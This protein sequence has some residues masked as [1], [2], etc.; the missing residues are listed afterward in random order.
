MK[1]KHWLLWTKTTEWG[2][3]NGMEGTKQESQS[4]EHQA[5]G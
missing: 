2:D 5:Q 1:E 4:N 3:G